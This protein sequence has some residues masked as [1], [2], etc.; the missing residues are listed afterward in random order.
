MEAY[1]FLLFEEGKH[2]LV[3]AC[4]VPESQENE[5]IIVTELQRVSFYN[6]SDQKSSK[7]WTARST[8]KFTHP[9]IQESHHGKQ[10]FVVENHK[11]IW[12]WNLDAVNID[13]KAIKKTFKK[14]YFFNFG[15]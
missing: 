7:A 4:F 11:S 13:D 1:S 3:G 10:L 15:E 8:V 2:K 5:E 6:V 14:K 9:A 12:S